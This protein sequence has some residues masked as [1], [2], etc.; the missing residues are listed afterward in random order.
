MTDDRKLIGSKDVNM[1]FWRAACF[2]FIMF[3][4]VVLFNESIWVNVNL[5]ILTLEL[6][7]VACTLCT[8]SRVSALSYSQAES[9]TCKHEHTL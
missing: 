1:I 7:L 8:G 3:I 6:F 9:Y 2:M 4:K 5:Y